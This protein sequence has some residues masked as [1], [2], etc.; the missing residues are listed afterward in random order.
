MESIARSDKWFVGIRAE[1]RVKLSDSDLTQRISSG[2]LW[3]IESDSDKA[4]FAEVTGDELSALTAELKRMGFTARQ[5][6]AVEVE[7]DTANCV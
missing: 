7:N 1:A 5:I 4:Y 2:G 6:K 3:G